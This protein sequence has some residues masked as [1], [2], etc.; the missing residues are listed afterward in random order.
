MSARS[1]FLRAVIL[2]NNYHEASALIL[3]GTALPPVYSGHNSFWYWGP[4]PAERTVVIHVG[5]WRPAD[6]SAYFLGCRDVARID[7]GLGIRNGEQGKSVSV[8][9]G[10]RAPWRA[11][12]SALRTIS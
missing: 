4:P 3:L 9:T 11:M 10:L 1:G 2:T 6:R 7:N 8:C 12:W 5:D